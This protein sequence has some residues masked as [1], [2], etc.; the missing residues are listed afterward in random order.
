MTRPA[1]HPEH[2]DAH[3]FVADESQ[4]ADYNGNRR[5][6]YPRCYLPESNSI[7][8][9]SSELAASLPAT[10]PEDVSDRILGEGAS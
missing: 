7:H 2:L 5:C 8:I 4:R 9:T 3:L 1:K 10:P 6:G